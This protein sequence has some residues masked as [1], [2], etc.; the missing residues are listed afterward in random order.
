MGTLQ[1]QT[2]LLKAIRPISK[3]PKNKQKN[4]S[5][6]FEKNNL[7]TDD[8]EVEFFGKY[9]EIKSVLWTLFKFCPRL[10]QNKSNRTP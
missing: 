3:L 2:P 1:G 8:R 9:V 4:I 5:R 6:T 10:E 7:R